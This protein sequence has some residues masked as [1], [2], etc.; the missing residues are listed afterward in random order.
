MQTATSRAQKLFPVPTRHNGWTALQ[1][2][3]PEYLMEGALLCLFM[4]SACIFGTLLEHPMSP[5]H[6]SIEVP[7]QRRLLM[8]LAMGSTLVAIV[9][10]PWGKRSGAHL[11]PAVTLTFFTLGKVAPW[12]ALF[13]V[14]SQFLGG[15]LGVFLA[16]M[17]VG[18]PLGHSAVNY[19][20]TVPGALGPLVAFG[21][22]MLICT[23]TMTTV[24][25]AS[26]SKNWSRYTG[27]FAAILLAT[28][29]TFEA[30]YSGVS[31]NPARTFSSAVIPGEWTAI[32]VYFTA[33]PLAMVLAA[34]AYRFHAGAHHVFC[35]KLHHDNHERCIFRCRHGEKN[36]NE[37]S[38]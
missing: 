35:A 3:W 30:P 26:N 33:P 22:E 24:L 11:N 27:L 14:L 2:H 6:Q 36:A 15:T 34:S 31:L 38:L 9:Y 29:I 8:G 19:V 25:I 7:M 10:S 37:P 1:N 16:S 5:L 13:Y 23:I 12:D 17:L 18:A 20:V 28:Y 21:A 32:W 4:I